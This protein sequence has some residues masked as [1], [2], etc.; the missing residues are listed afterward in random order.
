MRG[1]LIRSAQK[2]ARMMN[3]HDHFG[4]TGPFGS[5]IYDRVVQEGCVYG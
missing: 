1:S 3:K 4:H 5:T 2:Y